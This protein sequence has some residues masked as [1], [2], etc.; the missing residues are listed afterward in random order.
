VLHVVGVAVASI[1]H[2]ESLVRSMIDG[3]KRP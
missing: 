3:R 1:A 2:R